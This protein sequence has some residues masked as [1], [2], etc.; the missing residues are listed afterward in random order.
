MK[1]PRV[2]DGEDFFVLWSN[3]HYDGM[4][5]GIGTY[6]GQP[7]WIRATTSSEARHRYFRIYLITDEEF[8]HE[9]KRQDIFAKMIGIHTQYEYIDGDRKRRRDDAYVQPTQEAVS[10]CY[11]LRGPEVLKKEGRTPVAWWGWV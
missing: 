9:K 1:L 2:K 4:M 8:E 6:Q 7:C 10:E 3:T 5:S 11:R